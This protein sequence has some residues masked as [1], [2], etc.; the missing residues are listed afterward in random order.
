MCDIYCILIHVKLDIW[1]DGNWLCKSDCTNLEMFCINQHKMSHNFEITIMMRNVKRGYRRGLLLS[2]I[3]M[4]CQ[5]IFFF[6]ALGKNMHNFHF[7]SMHLSSL[8]LTLIHVLIHFLPKTT[9][10]NK[11]LIGH[12]MASYVKVLKCFWHWRTIMEGL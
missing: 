7:N 3:M 8:K 12:T 11:I 5:Y 4:F 6:N 10:W 2:K 1:K 9:T